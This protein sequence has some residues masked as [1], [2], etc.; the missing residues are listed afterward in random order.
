MFVYLIDE[1][2][3]DVDAEGFEQQAEIAYADPSPDPDTLPAL[4]LPPLD[5]EED[6]P[7]IVQDLEIVS[8]NDP[9]CLVC[10]T[11]DTATTNYEDLENPTPWIQHNHDE[12]VSPFLESPFSGPYNSDSFNI[13]LTGGQNNRWGTQ[14]LV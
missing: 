10:S 6:A 9:D 8:E 12:W 2:V 1:N 14:G 4:P 7:E 13:W 11:C 5:V 3:V